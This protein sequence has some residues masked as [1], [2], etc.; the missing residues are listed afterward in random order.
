LKVRNVIRVQ[1]V[2]AALG[3]ALVLLALGMALV[4]ASSV[5]AQHDLDPAHSG[6]TF[7]TP[8]IDKHAAVRTAQTSVAANKESSVSD[9]LMSLW[10]SE[11]TIQEASLVRLMLM[12]TMMIVILMI[13]VGL[14]VLCATAATTRERRLH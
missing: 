14:L 4:L 8:K 7:G 6:M 5:R 2:P 13:G 9:V 1:M 12:E 11:N 10:S 3:A